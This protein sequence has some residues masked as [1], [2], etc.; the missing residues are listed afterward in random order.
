[1]R[2]REQVPCR[3]CGVARQLQSNR[4]ESGNCRDCS[5]LKLVAFDEPS[6]PVYERRGLIWKP[7][8]NKCQCGRRHP[9]GTGCPDCLTWAERDAIRTSWRRKEAA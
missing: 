2:A 6:T 4:V 8:A 9:L 7:V 3:R 1:M 5:R